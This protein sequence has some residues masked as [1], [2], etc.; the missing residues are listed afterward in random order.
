MTVTRIMML[1]PSPFDKAYGKADP[2]WVT[3]HHRPPAYDE[4]GYCTRHGEFL[5]RVSRDR[6][7]N[8]IMSILPY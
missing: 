7:T 2:R 6:K 4:R 8:K 5:K 1:W 3:I